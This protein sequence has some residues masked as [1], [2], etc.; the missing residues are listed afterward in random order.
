MCD[1]QI[2]Q[3]LKRAAQVKP[4]GPATVFAGRRRTWGET[5]ERVA[6]LAGGLGRLGLSRGARA[7]ILA[8]N[9][10][11]Y[12]EYLFA[13]P[14]AGGAAVPIN[15][16]LAAPEIAYILE[17]SGSE[18]LFVDEHH[19]GVLGELTGKMA[20]VRE[21]VFLGEVGVPAG[22]RAYEDLLEGGAAPDAMG[23]D[24]DLAG[25]FY[26]GGTTGRAKG[27]MLSHRN[28]VANAAN[29]IAG[30]GYDVDSVYLHAA[31]MFHLADGASTLAVT[32][33]GG[34][35]VFVPR[36]DPADCLAAIQGERVTHAVFVPTMINMLVNF[37]RIGAH[38]VSTLGTIMFGGSPMPEAVLRRALG[39]LPRCRFI[40]GYGM[41][42]VA[43]IAT[44]LDPRYATLEGP[45]AG[46]LKS[47]G[48]AAVLCE[49]TIADP[50]EQEVPR[51]TVGE[52]LVRG[53]NVMLGYWN[54][55]DATA[56][57]LRGGWMH[58][59]DR[60]YM[61]EE[62]FVYIVDRL[63]DMIITGGENVYSME[64]ESAISTL[65]GVA[66]VAVIGIPDDMWGESV[67]AIVVPRAGRTLTPEQV[68]AHCRT[69]IAGY[70]CPRSVEIRSDSLPLS[71]AGKILKTVLREPFWRG[72]EQRLS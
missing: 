32:M 14:W 39:V 42:E 56:Q 34:T 1:V 53:P 69:L 51:G 33:V 48:R 8:L 43:P 50:Q 5:V 47:C 27:V 40:H 18:I 15:I 7:A 58:T 71:G 49:V 29:A 6:R 12:F 20:R 30:I 22:A 23:G 63:K 11:R 67:H 4:G 66:E 54:Q 35:H 55:P 60:G 72:R 38:D 3:G 62:G 44:L 26:T 10:D 2:T 9:S 59:G 61:D 25:I 21:V 36:F 24:D 65:D 45:Y 37:P 57:A 64:V 70:K 46:R 28:L 17:D 16:R 31:P 13:V 68:I 19:A 41:T 52:V